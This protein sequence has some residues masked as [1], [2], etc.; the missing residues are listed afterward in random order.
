MTPPRKRPAKS[1]PWQVCGGELLGM[2]QTAMQKLQPN[3]T[4]QT[5]SKA[6]NPKKNDMDRNCK[7]CQRSLIVTFRRSIDFSVANHGEAEMSIIFNGNW[8]KCASC[9]Y[10]HWHAPD[11]K[12]R[13]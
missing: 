13:E 4:A 3:P 1:K 11:K 9:E 2:E 6:D 7:A 5:Q 12:F 8:Q 10:W